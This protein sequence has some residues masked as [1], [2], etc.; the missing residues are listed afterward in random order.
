MALRAP[1]E[2]GE[3]TSSKKLPPTG[4]KTTKEK[5]ND[6]LVNSGRTGGFHGHSVD[7]RCAGNGIGGA[8]AQKRCAMTTTIFVLWVLMT[9][10]SHFYGVEIGPGWVARAVLFDQEA[11]DL[12]VENGK[13]LNPK[14]KILCLPGGEEPPGPIAEQLTKEERDHEGGPTEE[15]EEKEELKQ[16][17]ALGIYLVL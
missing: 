14:G 9:G 2:Q 10:P 3:K 13:F 6:A 5:S 7:F 1:Y 17:K 11:C 15:T 12:A 16:F 8:A 4:G